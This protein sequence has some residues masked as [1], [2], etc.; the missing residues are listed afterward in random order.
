MTPFA[1]GL[2]K[3]EELFICFIHDKLIEIRK[4]QVV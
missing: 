3:K 4:V 2:K 1:G